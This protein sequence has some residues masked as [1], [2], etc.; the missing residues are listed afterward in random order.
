MS[1]ANWNSCTKF[2]N[3]DISIK[4]I[5]KTLRSLCPPAGGFSAVELHHFCL[6]WR[7]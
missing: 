5:K 7:P 6:G 4:T 2:Q 3:G 1:K